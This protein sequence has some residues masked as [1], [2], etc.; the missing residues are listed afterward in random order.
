[1]EIFSLLSSRGDEVME[2]GMFDCTAFYLGIRDNYNNISI[3]IS[4]LSNM[5]LIEYLT[6]GIDKGAYEIC[7]ISA[8]REF[9]NFYPG[10]KFDGPS[11]G[12][13]GASFGYKATLY[14]NGSVK[15]GFVTAGHA[16]KYLGA[17]VGV[18]GLFGTKLGTALRYQDSGS[19]DAAFVEI[20]K[21]HSFYSNIMALTVNPG[22]ST[23]PALGS[24]VYKRGMVT[25]TTYG[26]LDTVM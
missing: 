25:F 12:F 18:P 10:D 6:N 1:M 11:P 21:P 13:K 16:V 14:D 4:D 24:L 9:A 7:Q 2:N 19:V 26:Y 23:I 17:E 20:S 3:G 15:H 5:E 22:M 8:P